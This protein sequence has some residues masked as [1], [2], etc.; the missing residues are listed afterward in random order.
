[1]KNDSPIGAV[2]L[3]LYAEND[4]K[5]LTFRNHKPNRAD[6]R[7]LERMIGGAD[8]KPS[9]L[10]RGCG[11]KQARSDEGSNPKGVPKPEG[12]NR[13]RFLLRSTC[14]HI[15]S[16]LEAIKPYSAIHTPPITQLGIVSRKAIRGEM[17]EKIMHMQ[18]A[19]QM[20]TVEAFRVMATQAMDSP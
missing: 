13:F 6:L 5:A 11:V 1:M 12:A 2:V 17:K 9:R 16:P 8:T 14:W 19:P 7:D 4:S 20:L 18:A 10:R 15:F 3:H